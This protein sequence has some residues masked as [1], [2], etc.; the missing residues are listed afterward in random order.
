[1][2]EMTEREKY[3][4][5]LQGFLVVRDFLTPEEVA[6][7]NEAVDSQVDTRGQDG[8]SHTGQSTT[9][10]GKKRGMFTGMLNWPKPY[11]DPFRNL[12]VHPKL[13]PYLNSMHG[14]GWRLDHEPFILTADKGTEGLTLHGPGMVKFDGSQYYIYS[15]GQMRCG[16]VV[17]QFQ[18]ADVNAG[19]GGLCVI[20]GSHKANFAC[21]QKVK[22]WE[23]D[24]EIV[25]NVPSKA[26]DLIIFNEA[27]THGTLP[28]KADHERR[29]LLVRYSPMY[30][31][32]AGGFYE[33]KFPDWVNELTDAQ[34]AVLEPP[35]IYNRPLI[36]DDGVTVVHPRRD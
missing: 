27:T 14:R 7:L 22:E 3:L 10:T 6:A 31:H 8:N 36:E 11:C 23:M 35:Y 4:Y 20:P 29:S 16:M 15:N 5:D 17:F 34:R 32:F 12:V 2:I 26:G 19:D 13:L 25:Y 28:W 21:P 30:L 18:L 33:T 24:Q 9:L 1:M